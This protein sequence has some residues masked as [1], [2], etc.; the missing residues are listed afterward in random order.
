M[1][2]CVKLAAAREVAAVAPERPSSPIPSIPTIVI[3]S[4]AWVS[5]SRLD[6]SSLAAVAMAA[7]LPANGASDRAVSLSQGVVNAMMWTKLR[8]MLAVLQDIRYGIR[9][10]RKRA[11][12]TV[13][14]VVTLA[15]GIGASTAIFSV[16]YGVLLRPLPYGQVRISSHIVV[17]S[18]SFKAR[19]RTSR[20]GFES[21]ASLNAM[22]SH[23]R[24]SSILPN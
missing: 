15:L 11:G 6:A 7:G 24:A 21:A 17:R 14:A 16:V 3:S 1:S 5:A 4:F 18:G 2:L 8:V 22:R 20:C 23:F 19:S 12:F 13:I 9:Q 10:L